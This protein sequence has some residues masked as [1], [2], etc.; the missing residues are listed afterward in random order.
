MWVNTRYN[1]F[2]AGTSSNKC[3]LC[4]D[5]DE[6]KIQVELMYLVFT[7]MR[8]RFTAREYRAF[9][10]G[11][12]VASF[13]VLHLFRSKVTQEQSCISPRERKQHD[14]NSLHLLHMSDT[15]DRYTKGIGFWQ[16]IALISPT[17]TWHSVIFDFLSFLPSFFLSFFLSF[18]S[19]F[20]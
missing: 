6:D 5:T 10:V 2:T 13:S 20:D 14:C 4:L 16:T 7:C 12:H 15:E 17:S 1:N 9:D 11:V 18:S 8:V 3:C 19:S